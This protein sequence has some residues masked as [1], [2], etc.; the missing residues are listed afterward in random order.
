MTATTYFVVMDCG[1]DTEKKR[2]R[3]VIDKWEAESRGKVSEVKAIVVKADL[4]DIGD[5]LDDLYS[6][7]SAGRIETYRAEIE[8]IEPEK[9]TESLKVTFKNDIKSVE[10][11]ISFIFSKKN[12]TLREH[13]YLHDNFSEME[14]MV[15]MRRGKGGVSV[16]VVLMGEKERVGETTA[17]IR[18][19]GIEDAPKALKEDLMRDFAYFDVKLED[20]KI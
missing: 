10:R 6:R 14:Y 2:V 9:R 3:Y 1:D 18:L 17:D 7:M 19:E 4:D 11:L 16:K 13:R 15:Y 20:E 8:K 5:F 12:S